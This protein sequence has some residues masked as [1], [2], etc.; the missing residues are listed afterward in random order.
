L[1]DSILSS[2]LSQGEAGKPKLSDVWA[3][4]V[5]ARK[6][7]AKLAASVSAPKLAPPAADSPH[8]RR[9]TTS[10]SASRSEALPTDTLKQNAPVS[11]HVFP[12]WLL[13][14]EDFKRINDES[15]AAAV[16]RRDDAEGYIRSELGIEPRSFHKYFQGPQR[17]LHLRRNAVAYTN[18][19]VVRK[20]IDD[21]DG[22]SGSVG[23]RRSSYVR[24]EDLKAANPAKPLMG[25]GGTLKR[26]PSQKQAKSLANRR[27]GVSVSA[28]E[29]EAAETQRILAPLEVRVPC[30]QPRVF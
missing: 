21:E 22:D 2:T 24:V 13:S 29:D 18:A 27:A 6:A 3:T 23:S 11:E 7:V 17:T 14:R 8:S 28:V 5:A 30:T 25:T 20:P 15:L 9:P 12:D 26:A 16:S 19:N 10:V 1:W 4:A